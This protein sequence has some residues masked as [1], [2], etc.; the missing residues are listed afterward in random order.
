MLLFGILSSFYIY[1]VFKSQSL[2]QMFGLLFLAGVASQPYTCNIVHYESCYYITLWEYWQ[3][4]IIHTIPEFHLLEYIV[5]WMAFLA[6]FETGRFSLY[7]YR[8]WS[9]FSLENKMKPEA[10]VIIIVAYLELKWRCE[11]CSWKFCH[12]LSKW[13]WVENTVY[14]DASPDSVFTKFTNL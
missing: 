12:L 5:H 9:L 11:H 10:F 6:I 8:L 13:K 2:F 1:I 4:L 7:F 14:S 3:K